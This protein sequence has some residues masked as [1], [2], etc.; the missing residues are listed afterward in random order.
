MSVKLCTL[1]TRGSDSILWSS[2]SVCSIRRCCVV[3]LLF[4]SSA[5]PP[6]YRTAQETVSITTTARLVTLIHA[7]HMKETYANIQ[8]LLKKKLR[9]PPVAH[10]CRCKSCGNADWI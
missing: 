2:Y 6:V 1:D 4:N 5:G 9:R 10:M 8:G 3:F 7:V